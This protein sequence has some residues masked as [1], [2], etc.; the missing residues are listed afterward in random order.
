MQD[1]FFSAIPNIIVLL[2]AG[3]LFLSIASI[4]FLLRN[5]P[6]PYGDACS[7][8]ITS[9][10]FRSLLF[11]NNHYLVY[12]FKENKHPTPADF[13]QTLTCPNYSLFLFLMRLC[14]EENRYEMTKKLNLFLLLCCAFIW[15]GNL[16]NTFDQVENTF[17][18]IC[19]LLFFTLIMSS[20]KML[21][22]AV[23]CL[24]DIVNF[25]LLGITVMLVQYIS[26]AADYFWPYIALGMV[27]GLGMRNRF[28]DFLVLLAVMFFLLADHGVM[29]LVVGGIAFLMR[30]DIVLADF[31]GGNFFY[32]VRSLLNM[33]FK[34]FRVR[35]QNAQSV[36][37]KDRER[38]WLGIA[39]QGCLTIL[40]PMAEDSLWRSV[41]IGLLLLPF[42]I[43][44][45]LHGNVPMGQYYVLLLY[46]IGLCCSGLFVRHVAF[47]GG[48]GIRETYYFGNRQF[49]I[50]FLIVTFI[51]CS[52]FVV[53]LHSAAM[54]PVLCYL[55]YFISFA[56]AQQRRLAGYKISGEIYEPKFIR[57]PIK[58]YD[59]M[60]EQGQFL[61]SIGDSVV[62]LGS[63][64]QFGNAANFYHWKGRMKFIDLYYETSESFMQ[65]ILI[66]HQVTHILVSPSCCFKKIINKIIKGDGERNIF[67]EQIQTQSPGLSIYK[68]TS[69]KGL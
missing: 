18:V 43:Y 4:Y 5:T 12:W 40:N 30:V 15:T 45:L 47:G 33:C 46:S 57:Y 3:C 1:L 35:R 61:N 51:N 26:M 21:T 10:S 42:S 31:L 65:S 49:Y 29:W 27:V 69:V 50:L 2:C 17:V 37:K 6:Y 32:N 60:V 59:W 24:S 53:L 8:L 54:V 44:F 48:M 41:G 11:W 56:I 9:F 16:Y 34:P 38:N 13:G 7:L 66:R 58:P 25:I 36:Q 62:V 67:L 39:R 28:Q 23:F 19:A 63:Y 52:A 55:I 20:M 22:L 64:L 14:S 68:V